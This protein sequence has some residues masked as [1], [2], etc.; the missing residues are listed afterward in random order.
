MTL[1]SVDVL[2]VSD[3]LLLRHAQLRA[4]PQAHPRSV[5]SVSN[6]LY[7]NGD[8]IATEE[9]SYLEHPTDLVP[10]VPKPRSF[11]R[12]LLERSDRFRLSRWWQSPR[13]KSPQNPELDV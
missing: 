10:L 13:K 12:R 8:P 11:L 3:E 1:D 4:L 6:W 7:N 5:E 2:T 9:T